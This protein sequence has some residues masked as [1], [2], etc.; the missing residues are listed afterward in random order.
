M[1]VMVT[2][3]TGFVGREVL[4]QLLTRGH[5]VRIVVRNPAA[6]A[7]RDAAARFG[8]ELR[9]GDVVKDASLAD[10]VRGVDAVIHLVGIIGEIGQNTFENAHVHATNHVVRAATAA[11]AR[12]YVQMSALG[13]RPDAVARYHQTKWS[14]E[15][16]VRHS[17]LDA[18]IFRPSLIYGAEDHFVNLFATLSRWSPM[19]PVMGSGQ[20][21]LQPVAVEAV[22]AALVGALTDPRAVGQTMDLCGPE[23]LTFLAV[24]DTILDVLRRRRFKLRVPLPLARIQ[25]AA[26]EFI[27]PTLLGRAAPLN[28]DQLIMLQE[29]NVGDPW[30]AAEMFGLKLAPFREGIA[31]YLRP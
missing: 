3:A 15:E 26:L 24:L 6:A 20:N 17:G 9:R 29:D 21:R 1:N 10:A 27:F 31:A 12:R 4:R 28:R 22:A 16:I 30:P 23:P 19:L 2:G 13:T 7:A 14:A 5:A 18:T 8:V 25:A 11:G